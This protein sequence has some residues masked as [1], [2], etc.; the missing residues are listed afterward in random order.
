MKFYKLFIL[1]FLTTSFHDQNSAH[2]DKEK[3]IGKWRVICPQDSKTEFTK[4]ERFDYHDGYLMAS[5]N[6]DIDDENILTAI[7]KSD[8]TIY[9][10][11]ITKLT[12][13]SLV[14]FYPLNPYEQKFVR[15][16]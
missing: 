7:D 6:Y 12:N 14:M 4:T 13:D 2:I 9:R 16:K 8:G 3:I 15:I 10:W 11:Q 5:Y 1:L